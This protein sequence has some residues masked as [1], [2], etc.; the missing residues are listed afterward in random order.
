MATPIHDEEDRPVGSLAVGSYAPGRS[1]SPVEQEALLAFA[2]HAS[3]ALSDARVHDAMVQAQQ[4]RDMFLAMVS[5]ELK[6]P[7][8]VVMAALRT[9]ER[10]N[11]DLDGDVRANL[12]TSAFE[13]GR[14]LEALIDRLLESTRAELTSIEQKVELPE[15]VTSALRGFEH[16]RTLHCAPIEA[17]PLIADTTAVRRILE[18]LLENAIAHS[19]E[20]TDIDVRARVVDDYVFI[21]IRNTGSLP[22]GIDHRQ[23]FAPF[24]R[25]P[26]AKSSGVGLG[27]HIAGRLAT[28]I[29]GD[30]CARSADGRVTFTLAFPYRVP[31]RPQHTEAR[32][33]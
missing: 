31:D 20:G 18:T 12:V 23:L 17:L 22:E 1:F 3:L 15:L 33:A 21:A 7:L 13:R 27:L 9:I 2:E 30:I 5:H 28:S 19:P 24:R 14:Q 29:G 4:A 26:G 10:H 6:T 11:D 8:T 16:S 32:S 25:G